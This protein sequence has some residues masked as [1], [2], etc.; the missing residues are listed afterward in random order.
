MS[1]SATQGGHKKMDLTDVALLG[2]QWRVYTTVNFGLVDTEARRLR[3]MLRG[4]GQSFDPGAYK[5]DR[6]RNFGFEA[7]RT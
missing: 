3:P 4:R 2:C 7:K 1:A 6:G 5:I